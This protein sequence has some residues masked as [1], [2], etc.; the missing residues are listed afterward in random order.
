MRSNN[1]GEPGRHP[2]SRPAQAALS[3]A[4]Q[5][6]V[7]SLVKLTDRRREEQLGDTATATMQVQVVMCA[8]NIAVI[9][10]ITT[11][12]TM[13]VIISITTNILIQAGQWV[14]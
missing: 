13:V 6:S 11:N 5:F 14:H 12:I 1:K 9:I 7:R 2:P 4:W 8:K 3:W 10:T